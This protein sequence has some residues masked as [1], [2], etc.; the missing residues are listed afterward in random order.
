MFLRTISDNGNQLRDE[1]QIERLPEIVPQ[2]VPQNNEEPPFDWDAFEANQDEYPHET[3]WSDEEERDDGFLEDLRLWAGECNI[4]LTSLS[5]LLKILSKHNVADVPVDART[6]VGT[7]KSGLLQC[8]NISGGRYLHFGVEEGLKECLEN[9]ERQPSG[10]ILLDINIDGLPIFNSKNISVWPIQMS[11]A[12][13]GFDNRPFVAGMFCG[14]AKPSDQDFLKKIIQELQ[15]L[16]ASGLNGWSIRER[17]VICDAPARALIKGIVQFNGRYGCD[18]CEVRGLFDGRMMF[19]E[20]GTLRTDASFRVESNKLHHKCPSEFLNLP[21]DMI[22][23]FPLDVMHCVDL[24]VTRRMLNYWKEGPR[25]NRLTYTQLQRLSDMNEAVGKHFPS[26]FNRKPRRFDELKMWKA[27]EFRTFLLYVGPVILREV[28]DPTLY[29]LFVS[30][31]VAISLLSNPRLVREHADY[32][33][34]LLEYFVEQSID[35]FGEHF[36]TYNV[37]SL[38][39]LKQFA[40]QAGCLGECSA[41]KFENHMTTIKRAVRGSGDPLVQIA[42]R[43]A[44]KKQISSLK[45]KQAKK[46]PYPVVKVG[47]YYELC[48]GDIVCVESSSLEGFTCQVFRL[49]TLQPIFNSPCD[50]RMIGMYKGYISRIEMDIVP[51]NQFKCE[52]IGIPNKIMEPTSKMV[53]LLKLNHTQ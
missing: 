5:K 14:G 37:H 17:F 8:E 20:K 25:R 48:E 24:G 12:T 4:P 1:R 11:V 31:S 26:A 29:S 30:L 18:N 16:R 9:V 40:V 33:D 22:R 42:N 39:H 51:Q 2:N 50:S 19:L 10:E 34:T 53:T 15:H 35:I 3:E 23:Q 21:I 47:M 13:P 43:L 44:E 38:R 36:C 28:V 27:T 41:Y 52:A 46:V 32:A 7:P 6:L 49:R 45:T